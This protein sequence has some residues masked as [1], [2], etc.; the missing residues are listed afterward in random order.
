LKRKKK[1]RVK[2]SRKSVRKPVRRPVRV[3]KRKQTKPHAKPK[4]SHRKPSAKP[5][6]RSKSRTRNAAHPKPA[7]KNRKA[8][9][10]PAEPVQQIKRASWRNLDGLETV[11]DHSGDTN[12]R[13]LAG[14]T[15]RDSISNL[16]KIA[17]NRERNGHL[18][19]ENKNE[20]TH[21]ATVFAVIK[22][23]DDTYALH[24]TLF[25]SKHDTRSAKE[26]S[27][28]L[29]EHAFAGSGAGDDSPVER[30]GIYKGAVLPGINKKSQKQ[31]DIEK[32]LGFIQ[33]DL[34][35]SADS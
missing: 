10:T 23:S 20:S 24:E 21:R 6:K 25:E 26:W 8:S 31:W 9:R 3:H 35:K 7:S 11:T 33:H 15:L 13:A 16:E 4:R 34:R 19:R 5:G 1:P 14:R 22:S 17:P 18:Y 29:A 28:W 27:S 2:P 12:G 32:V 30:L